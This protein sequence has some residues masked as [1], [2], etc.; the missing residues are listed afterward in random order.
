MTPR[1]AAIVRWGGR[2]FGAQVAARILEPLVADWEHE[3]QQPQT[4]WRRCSGAVRWAAALLRT[5]AAVA[6]SATIRPDDAAPPAWRAIS[7][8][9]LFSCAGTILLMLPFLSWASIGV[10][11]MVRALPLLIPQ[12]GAIALPF[13][14]LPAAM[15]FGAAERSRRPGAWRRHVATLVVAV[16]LLTI[17]SIGWLVPAANQAWRERV[18]GGRLPRGLRER[19]PLELWS[20]EGLDRVA[21]RQELRMKLSVSVLWPASLG[22]LGWRIGRRRTTASLSAMAAG[23]VGAAVV[24]AFADPL[25]LAGRDLPTTL[26]PWMWL[27]VAVVVPSPRRKKDSPSAP[28]RYFFFGR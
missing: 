3:L 7:V 12:A 21:A 2:V 8:L 11:R 14:I 13:A 18:S 10:A 19:T 22:I 26:L 6:W 17:P 28:A 16:S 23:W 25:R 15:V 20:A 4:R 5:V 1:R 9:V 24:V 27:L